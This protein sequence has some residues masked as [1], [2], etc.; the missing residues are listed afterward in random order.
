MSV[1]YNADQT[2]TLSSGDKTCTMTGQLHF[3][4]TRSVLDCC[5]DGVHSKAN[6]VING[7]TIHVFT[8]VS[9]NLNKRD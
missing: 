3:T 1:S 8:G 9:P 5:I 6:V 2:Y 7:D 4:D